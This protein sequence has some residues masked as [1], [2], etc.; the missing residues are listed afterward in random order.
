MV[1]I[2][3]ADNS[4][5]KIDVNKNHI[6]CGDNLDWLKDVPD[7]SVGLCYIDPPFFS[8]RNYEVIWGNGY[9]LR[10]FGDRFAGGVSHYIEWMRPRIELIHRKLKKSGSIFLHCDWHASHRLRCMLDDVFGEK[11]FV[12]EI[13]WQRVKTVKNNV[14]QGRLG[15]DPNTDTIFFYVKS[16]ESK[17][18]PVMSAYTDG[19]IDKM[20]RYVEPETGRRYRLNTLLGP[21][22]A[23]KGNP[24]YEVMGV[25]KHWRYSKEKM[26][27]LIE[28]GIV[29]Q[30]KPG[31]TPQRK[32]YLDEG[33]GVPIQSLWTDVQFVSHEN[34]GYPTQ[35]PEALIKRILDCASGPGDIVLDC[36][37]GGGTTAKVASATG[38]RFVVGDVSPV[39][40]KIMAERI[41]RECPKEK[42][43]LKNLPQS[44]TELRAMNG[45]V[46]A[47]T[48]CEMMGWDVNERRSGDGG[49]DGWSA[50]GHPIQVKNQK[51]AS[52]RPDMQKFFG[53]LA[54]EKKK[55][56]IFVAWE[57]SKDA[58]DFIADMKREHKV[59]IVPMRATEV[60][61]SLLLDQKKSHEV[62]VLFEERF[63]DAWLD[64]HSVEAD[65][66]KLMKG[67]RAKR[68]TKRD[69]EKAG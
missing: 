22:G 3:G 69:V 4:A 50:A 60:F 21:G 49:I 6:I 19:Y 29:V 64:E 44:A 56:G 58:M 55:Q 26:Q 10:S 68:K 32:Q 31:S 52:G 35:K 59:E 5:M 57:F 40:C 39:A 11:N 38:R 34:L 14:H 15:F 24:Y 46:F 47:E 62:Q 51:T 27:K 54:R 43:E 66:K 16:Q 53:A 67:I 45:H 61:G 18:Y 12:N 7:E 30:S 20:F 63:P 2:E 28:A 17:F 37:A 36:F 13:I 33:K 8:N 23:A 48:V 25:K 9:E 1:G 42:F 65:R 41:N